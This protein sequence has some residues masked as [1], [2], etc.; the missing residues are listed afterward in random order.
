MNSDNQ[1]FTTRA[2]V[3]VASL[4]IGVAAFFAIS[5]AGR[6]SAQE[7]PG[8]GSASGLVEPAPDPAVAVRVKSPAAEMH[9]TAG[10]PLRLLADAWGRDEWTCPPGH[11]PYACLDNVVEFF[12]DGVKVGDVHANPEGQNHWEVRLPGGIAQAGDHTLTTRYIPH[13]PNTLKGSAEIDGTIPVTIHVDARP[14][15]PRSITLTRDLVLSGGAPLDWSDAVVVGNGYRVTAAEGYHGP[16]SVVNAFVTGLGN[17]SSPGMDVTTEGPVTLENTIFE[18]TAPMHFVVNDSADV[19][20]RKNEFRA[21]NFVTYVA[22]NPDATPVLQFAG[23]TTGAKVF[24]GNN[25]AAG[26]LWIQGMSEWQIGGLTATDSNVFIGPRVQLRLDNC[27]NATIQGNYLHHE[28]KGGWSQGFNLETIGSVN[29]LA[30]HNVIREGSWPIQSFAGEFRYNL[31][32][33]QG[34][35]NSW[36]GSGDGTRVHH[37]VF[38][39]V[40]GPGDISGAVWLYLGE[41]GLEFDHNTFDMGGADSRYN[42]PALNITKGTL[43]TVRGNV[44]TGLSAIAAG[45]A[46]VAGG[47]A[48]IADADYNGFYNPLATAAARYGPGAV[49]KPGGHDTVGAD[50]QFQG[51]RD[52]PYQIPEGLVWT[53]QVSVF[54][55]LAYYRKKYTPGASSPLIN[56]GGGA[57]NQGAISGDELDRFGRAGTETPVETPSRM[58]PRVTGLRI[59][60]SSVQKAAAT[61]VQRSSPA[62]RLRTRAVQSNGMIWIDDPMSSRLKARAAASSADWVALKASADQF[63]DRTVLPFDLGASSSST[64][65]GYAYQGSGWYEAVFTLGL[66]YQVSGRA[67]YAD[68]V[69]QIVNVIN[70]ETK[71]GNFRPLTV[72]SGFPTRFLPV[73]LGLAYAWC[74]NRFT[75]QEKSDTF[76]SINQWF[77]LYKTNQAIIDKNGPAFSNYFGGHLIGFGIAGLATAG[78]NPRGQEIA[79]YMRD[80]FSDVQTAFASGVFAGGYPLEGYTYGTNQFVRILQ[81]MAAVKTATGEDL[82]ADGDIANKIARNL[83]YTLK[84]NNWQFPD[85]A[86]DPGDTTGIMDRTLPTMLTSMASAEDAAYMQFFVQHVVPGPATI[87]ASPAIRLL[88]ESSAAP[89]DYRTALPLAYNSPGDEHLIVRTSW[90]E[91]A[92]WASFKASAA[93]LGTS[94]DV[95]GHDMRGAGHLAIQRGNDYLLVNS[96]QWKGPDGWGGQPQVFDGRSWRA[97]TLNYQNP[98]GPDYRGGQGYWGDGTPGTYDAGPGYAYKKIDLTSAYDL[99]G[100]S[101]LRSFVRSLVSL[102]DG[103]FVLLDRVRSAN[104]MDEKTLYFH[105]NANGKPQV[106]G[107]T[108]I[109]TVG[110]S[111][112][113]IRTVLPASPLI[114][115]VADPW[116]DSNL[117]PSTYRAEIADS[118]TSPEMTLLHVISATS[119]TVPMMSPTTAANVPARNMVGVT[120]LGAVPKTVLFAAD[121]SAQTA[122]SYTPGAGGMQLLFDMAP[123]AMFQVRLNDTVVATVTASDQ[124]VAAFKL[125]GAGVT[126]VDAVASPNISRSTVRQP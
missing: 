71:R 126:R 83:L 31:V 27:S 121:G 49:Q 118:A 108:L 69:R 87:E 14:V 2:A 88:W 47:S 102:M 123:G 57:T 73:S 5:N 90:G 119:S 117:A 104:A 44:F 107:N 39:Y 45:G 17:Y 52:N 63:L 96:G 115:V 16:I 81:Y 13:D 93:H 85:E 54:D 124:G 51:E 32:I 120:I 80:R 1:R 92:V 23:N 106:S 113:F 35:H 50:P 91:D 77:D 103:T 67:A 109:S 60:D 46:V 34:G 95:S 58:P 28:Y 74:G 101:S 20:I 40:G 53:R 55:V 84:P 36:R 25:V 78:A 19:T 111:R 8:L 68:K 99:H 9:F 79:D 70:A 21:N 72:D 76:D 6:A 38:A 11:P 48:S 59:V 18:A 98:W 64:Q 94:G 114:K 37:N 29:L 22:S 30:E 4:L 105:F 41:R 26:Y 112:L 75:P 56:T 62:E 33:D 10:L 24:A 89:K 61:A 65:I 7:V 66:A 97:N 122:V 3:V 100:A 12:V 86:D 15:R 110:E 43:K 82:F 42:A 116:S 125:P